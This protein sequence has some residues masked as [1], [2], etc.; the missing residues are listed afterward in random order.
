MS[1]VFSGA[2]LYKTRS[3]KVACVCDSGHGYLTGVVLD[4][5]DNEP[6]PIPYH[7]TLSGQSQSKD[8]LSAFDIVDRI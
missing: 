1:G 8:V 3:G 2:G 7:W 4:A 6:G 5:I